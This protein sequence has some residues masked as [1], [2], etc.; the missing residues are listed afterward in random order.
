MYKRKKKVIWATKHKSS[1][2]DRFSILLSAFLGIILIVAILFSSGYIPFKKLFLP[3]EE[4]YFRSAKALVYSFEQKE[5]Y[6]QTLTGNKNRVVGYIVRYNFKVNGHL[7]DKEEQISTFQNPKY[8]L[9]IHQHLNDE[10]FWVRYDIVDPN[11]CY[12]IKEIE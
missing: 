2:W 8:V 11:N 9:Y 10:V 7:F 5:M 6:I 4:N 1:G 3:E 12:L